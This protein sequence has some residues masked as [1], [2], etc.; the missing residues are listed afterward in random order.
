VREELEE[1]VLR[2]AARAGREVHVGGEPHAVARA[3]ALEAHAPRRAREER[4]PRA[5]DVHVQVEREVEA[6]PT[7]L[8]PQGAHAATPSRRR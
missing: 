5:L 6:R 3:A 4:G 2:V 1:E 8:A 7:H